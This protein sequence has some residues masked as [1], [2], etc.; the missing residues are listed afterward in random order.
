MGERRCGCRPHLAAQ[1]QIHKR[2]RCRSVSKK[3]RDL[4]DRFLGDLLTAIGI[5][6]YLDPMRGLLNHVNM[7][8]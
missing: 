4:I 7:P 8:F 3:R 5:L 1:E 2:K 6:L